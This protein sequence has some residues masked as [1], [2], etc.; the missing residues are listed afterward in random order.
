[1]WGENVVANAP[2]IVSPACCT[3]TPFEAAARTN[4]GAL[5][6]PL[7]VSERLQREPQPVS[8]AWTPEFPQYDRPPPAA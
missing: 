2:A 1:V 5:V 3:F 8:K 6:V 4:T 7:R